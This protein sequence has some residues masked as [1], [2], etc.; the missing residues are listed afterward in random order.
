MIDVR[1]IA[2]DIVAREGGF[3]NDPDDPGGAT[4]HGIT[5]GTMRR[6]GVDVDHDGDVDIEDV[7]K[8]DRETAVGIVLRHYY[9]APGISRLPEC[10]RASVFDMYVNA[11][12]NAVKILQQLL[13]DMGQVIA[14]DGAIGPMTAA[15]AE[16]ARAAAPRHLADAYGIARRN[17]YYRLGDR[18]PSLRK[19]ARRR[20]G[21]KGGWITRAK[22][23][24]SRGYHLTEAE[25]ARRVSG[26]A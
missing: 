23:F 19:Y 24:I 14:V 22:T 6:L 1:T 9:E 12:R 25:H 17:Y 26:W 20:D 5:I 15:A 21:G 11:G 18:S 7:H 10:I 2:E 13:C 16:A 8:L 4:N 3:V